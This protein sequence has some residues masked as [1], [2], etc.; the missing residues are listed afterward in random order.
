VV[1]IKDPRYH[2]F[3]VTCA[4][5]EKIE[6]TGSAGRVHCSQSVVDS[7]EKSGASAGLHFEL[8]DPAS[9]PPLSENA[10]EDEKKKRSDTVANINEAKGRVGKSYFATIADASQVMTLPKL[11]H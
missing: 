4:N 3:G 6:S 9:L 5:A 8:R 10:T 11:A 7:I 1:G 2:L